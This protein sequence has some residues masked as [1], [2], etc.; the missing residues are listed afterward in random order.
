MLV[1][2]ACL[3]KTVS[4]VTTLL[5]FISDTHQDL[6]DADF[7]EEA[8]WQ[9]GTQLV[10]HIFTDDMDK[11]RSFVREI[12]DTHSREEMV[13]VVLWGNFEIYRMMDE[14]M[15]FGMKNHPS[16]SSEYVKFLVINS[17]GRGQGDGGGDKFER[18]E[19]RVTEV[20]KVVKSAKS[21]SGSA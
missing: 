9:L 6:T 4:F 8:S 3:D 19:E 12:M 15:R 13:G 5:T 17:G 14:Y 1:A 20:E 7:P 2:V 21:A 11:L 16:I 10:N 18:L